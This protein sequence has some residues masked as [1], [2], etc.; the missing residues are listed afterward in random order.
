MWGLNQVA[1]D[2]SDIKTRIH[3][4]KVSVSEGININEIIKLN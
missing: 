3:L 1:L 4:C 2:A